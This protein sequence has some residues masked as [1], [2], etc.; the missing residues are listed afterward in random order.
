MADALASLATTFAPGVEE[1]MTVPL[2]SR[3]VIRPDDEDSE[4]YLNIICVLM[5]DAEDWHQP[6]S[7]Y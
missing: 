5:V 6:I 1:D 3:W 4:A 2:Y 7:E